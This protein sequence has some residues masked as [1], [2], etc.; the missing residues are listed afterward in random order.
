MITFQRLRQLPTIF[1]ICWL[2]LYA[3]LVCEYHG[4]LLGRGSVMPSPSMLDFD[5]LCGGDSGAESPMDESLPRFTAKGLHDHRS[6]AQNVLYGF[7][8]VHIVSQITITDTLQVIRLA[9]PTLIHP[10]S[11]TAPPPTPPPR[12][13]T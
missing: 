4:V 11:L 13:L 10:I 8:T 2:A 6:V 7:L 12:L 5:L 1:L 3:P 9:P